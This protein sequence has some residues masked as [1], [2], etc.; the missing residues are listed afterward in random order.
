[1]NFINTH[2]FNSKIMQRFNDISETKY[3]NYPP[4]ISTTWIVQH[5]T[6]ARSKPQCPLLHMCLRV[7]V[8]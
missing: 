2:Y 4:I 3:T 6:N 1:M 5:L 8:D 7:Y